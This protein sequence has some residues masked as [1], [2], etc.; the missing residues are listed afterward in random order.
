MVREFANLMIK[1]DFMNM[2]VNLDIK[3]FFY[4]YLVNSVICLEILFSVCLYILVILNVPTQ[5][6]DN[7]EHIHSSVLVAR[8]LVPYRDFF[9]HHNPLLW[10]IFTPI[11]KLFDYNATLSEVVS[12]ISFL[13]F[14]K[15]LVY[16]Y[17]IVEE[18]LANKFWGLMASVLLLIPTYKV[19]AIDFR[20]DNYMVFCL[21]GGI[22]YYFRYLRDK[23]SLQLIFAFIWFVLSFL[24][25]Q[26]ALFPLFILGCTGIWFLIKKEIYVKDLLKALIAPLVMMGG[27]FL[28]LH[29]HDM[30]KLYYVANFVFNLNLVEGFEINKVVSLLPYM[31][32]WFYIGILSS[33]LALFSKNKYWKVLTLLFVT[34]LL[35][36]M[37][38]FSP[39]TYYFWFLLY[40]SV[41]LSVVILAKL[42]NKNRLVR[43]V[44]I[45]VS[46]YFL[47]QAI[48][49]HAK[50]IKNSKEKP[51]LPDYIT[52]TISPCDYVFNG[53]GFM[54][55]IFGKDPH[56][57]WQLIGQLDVVGE[58]SGLEAKP[59][60]NE[61]IVK[62]KPRF[63]FGGNYF[64]KFAR[65]AGRH[66]IVHYL[67]KKILDTY[68][69][70]S[71]FANIYE[72][73][74]E[75]IKDC[76]INK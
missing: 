62:Y 57:Y 32:I 45:A 75:Y 20:P 38:Y 40:V 65:E 26:K 34:E 27:F 11:T 48:I 5:N 50:I 67:D 60:M 47:Y 9:Q 17:R 46:C 44:V 33:I 68:Y 52:R 29:V 73:K 66:E 55:N 76:R 71:S 4:K 23:K 58:K 51:Y 61:L 53:D 16:V 37:F 8:G 64:N 3:N 13:V 59:N 41:I 18:F 12:F 54:Y 24:F 15:S 19:Y 31:K 30:V 7:I 63:I 70:E 28:Y 25:A 69:K 74:D 6:G 42:D 72:L 43:V 56:Y 21:M 2:K 14:L 22:F 36:R 10:Y 1:Q 39:Y 49:F 35:Q